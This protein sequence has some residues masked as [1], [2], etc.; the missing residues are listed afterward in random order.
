MNR[1]TFNKLLTAGG[2]A[3]FGHGL[4]PRRADARAQ[5]LRTLS[6]AAGSAQEEW[7]SRTFRRL[8]VDTHVPDWDGLLTDF[9]V[10]DYVGTIAR[11]GFQALMQ[12]ANSHVGLSLWRTQIG[13]MHKGMKGRDY[14]GEVMAECRRQGIHPLGYYSLVFDDWAYETHPDWRILPAQG[15]EK[16]LYSRMGS[17]CPNSPYREHALA[18]LRELTKN[19]DFE[20]MFLDM[21]FWPAVCYCPHC[22]ERF[23]REHQAEPPRTVNWNDPL[24]RSFQNAREQWMLEFAKDVTA[25]IKQT[26]PIQVYH[27]SG[28]VFVPW[29]FG[30]PLESHVAS[31]F[32]SGDFNGEPAKFS[33]VCK[34][35]LSLSL[36][37][38]FELMTSRTEGLNDF[39]TTKPAET[40]LIE[41]L[42]PTIHSSA[43]LMID[44]VKPDGTLNH[45][46]YEYM[47]QVNAQHDPYE[48]FLGGEMLADVAIYYDKG[49]M[50]DPAENGKNVAEAGSIEAFGGITK[51]A[52]EPL[53]RKDPPHM[54]AVL[55][56][57]RILREA[58]IPFGIVTN[59]TLEQLS[60]Y[61]AVMLPSVLEVTPEQAGRFRQFVKDGGVL[62]ASGPSTL[63][64]FAR[65][66]PPL[67]ELLGVRMMK[68][69]GAVTTYLTASDAELRKI[70]W[71]QE[72]ITFSGP[73][74]QAQALEG[75]EVLATAT[76]PFAEPGAGY[77]IGQHFAQIWSNPPATKAGTDP[78]IV[79]HSYGK[80]KNV[81]AAAPIES[82]TE[83]VYARI[84]MH[85]LRRLLPAPYHFEADTHRAVEMTLFHQAD[86]Q[87]MLASLLN[88]PVQT[89]TIPVGA[90]VRILIPDGRKA[91]RVVLLPEQKT[92][93]FEKVGPYIQFTVPPFKILAMAFV[94]YL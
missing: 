52:F 43:C 11:A 53:F 81:W 82:R 51:S 30:V 60:R 8:L 13:Q 24:W 79:V 20:A 54:D 80:G 76:M 10:A 31:D 37:P 33:L 69:V 36:K 25:A 12:Y 4:N 27:Q 35:F 2:V 72:N 6:G 29:R 7:P 1:R 5:Q 62:Y 14:F 68:S 77:T 18:C 91:T 34:T 56:A 73:L 64:T 59:A 42:F 70:T 63:D 58:H 86:K 45:A 22:T 16:I 40:L 19:Y 83:S 21:T 15:A 28:P 85:L 88:A 75:T 94:E 65:I 67:E 57:T 32:C 61:R 17:V 84:V 3:G 46:A 26:R 39:E 55:G 90:T 78:G 87:R 23:W 66:G 44:A 48:K 89:P 74:V 38:P 71:P 92:V 9:D 50:Y 93:A 49:S 47:G 41:T